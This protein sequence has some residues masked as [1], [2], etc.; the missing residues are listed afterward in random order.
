LP[1]GTERRDAFRY[2]W[3]LW[4]LPEL[5]EAMTDAG[6]AATK[7]WADDPRRP[8]TYRPISRMDSEA[9]GS[10]AWVVYLSATR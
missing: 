10:D 2:D 5:R 4:H 7:V 6:F 1:D 9:A 8:G 3:R